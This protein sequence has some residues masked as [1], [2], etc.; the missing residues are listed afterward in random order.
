MYARLVGASG[1]EATASCVS[2]NSWKKLS[3]SERATYKAPAACSL[4][5]M[6]QSSSGA[7]APAKDSARAN[8]RR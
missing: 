6:I 8:S 1:V 2:P 7:L 3:C 5:M 4:N